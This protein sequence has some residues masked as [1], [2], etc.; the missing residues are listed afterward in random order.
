[1]PFG[2]TY[3]VY[4]NAAGK[5]NI[6]LLENTRNKDCVLGFANGVVL[7]LDQKKWLILKSDCNKIC[8]VHACLGVLSV[9]VVETEDSFVQYLIVVK[10]ASLIGQLFNC[11]AYRITDVNCLPL[12]GDLNQKLSDPR[13]IQIQKL[14]SCG[15]FLFGW[16]N[17]QN[18]FVDI[19]LS[20]QRQFLNNKKGDTR[21]HWNLTLRSHL[22][23]FGIDAEDWVTPC[24][25]GVIEVKTA[26]VGHQQ[27]KAC[28]ISRISSER[29]GT[30]FNVRG[31]NDFGNVANFIETEQV[32]C[33]LKVIFAYLLYS[34]LLLFNFD[35]QVIFYNDNVVS[36]VQVRGSV[37][38]F[39]DQPGIQV[40]SHKIKI[41]RSLEASIV[42]YEKHFRQLKNCYG[43]AAIINLLGTKNDENTLSE[44]YQTIHSDSTFDSVIPFISFDL[45]SKAKGSSRSECLKKFW[46]KLETLVNSHG[47]FHCNGSE[48]LRK[49]TGVLRV[50]CLD[51]LDRTN[52]VQSLVG[53]KILQQQLAALGLSDKAN[54]CTRFVELFKTCWTLNGDHCSK[55]Y[56]GTAAQE[57]KSK[58]KDASI[59]VSRTIQGN[60]MDKSKQQA[61]NFLLRNSKLGTDTVAQ[62]NCLLPNKNFHVY[63]SIGIS[64]IE[65]V[66]EFVDPCQLRLFC[67]D[68]SHQ[69]SYDIY[70][71]GL[72]EMV[73]LNASNVLNASVSNQNSWRDAFLK[74]LNSISEYVLLETI[75]L[76]GICLFVFVQP[77]LLVHI[78]DV[79]T[80]AV[81]TGF[82]GTIG[83]KGGTAISFTLGASSLCFICSHFTAGQSQVQERNDDYEGTCRRLR[84]PSGLN[85]FSHDFIFWFGDFNYRIDMTG[86]EVKQMVD[87][88]DYDSLRE[89]DQLIQQKMVGCVFI[90]FEEGLIN[91]APTYKYDAFSDNYDTSEKARVPA[92]TDRIFFRKRRPYFKAQDTCQLLVY[93]RAELKTS[94]HRPVGAVFNLHIG[95]TNVDK[96][97]DAV[98]DM[99][100]SMGP[101]DATVVVSVQSQR[102]MVPFVDSVL[103]KIRHLGIKALLTKCIGEHLFCTFGKSDDALA[104]LS[105]DGVK[106][107][108]NVLCVRLKTTDWETDCQNVVHQLFND[109]FD[110]NFNNSRLNDRRNNDYQMKLVDQA[111][112]LP[113]VVVQ[114]VK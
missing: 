76:V 33:F 13:I 72:Q 100:S 61:M 6:V 22:Q 52:S 41:N 23:Q 85:L 14:L 82:G 35:L 75:Q 45:H 68:A 54:I 79:S 21:F 24:I 56:T 111:I 112:C 64:L 27:A 105:M 4:L 88:R 48:L 78:R 34:L 99:V 32:D 89:A 102:D 55:L 90:E 107:G 98:E 25:C 109:D 51:C 31:V 80:A 11:E 62:I 53:L 103:E 46:P 94:D 81:K 74:E 37:P 96:L 59:S 18:A 38:L 16:S 114:Y 10:N 39:W 1:M 42:A 63:P 47:F 65:K 8:D 43:N 9:P 5:E 40:G 110:K 71:I 92:W 73:D 108:Q 95:H 113:V 7:S 15:L 66:E 49:Q 69:K 44:S 86:E 2:R 87:L 83:N 106:I 60:L 19:S 29:M 26:Y 30:R 12:W 57:G 67:G 70:A 17:S 36:H 104:A 20:M 28:I 97:R 77:E 84:F 58:F 3:S 91:F 101:R 50:N 93:C